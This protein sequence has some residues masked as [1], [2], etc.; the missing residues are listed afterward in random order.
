MLLCKN[1]KNIP[2]IF[3]AALVALSLSHTAFAQTDAQSIIS[4]AENQDSLLSRIYASDVTITSVPNEHHVTGT[5]LIR[6]SE[7]ASI[8]NIQYEVMLLSPLQKG[9]INQLIADAPDVYDRVRSAEVLTLKS[10]EKR[11]ID[12]SYEAP[13]VPQGS[14]RLRIQIVTTNDRK[15]G[16]DDATLTLGGATSFLIVTPTHVLA[17]SSDPITKESG[18]T[19]DPLYGVN[20]DPRSRIQFEA[21]IKNTGAD[22]LSGTVITSTKRLLYANQ[23]QDIATQQSISI[24]ATSSKTITIPVTTETTPGAY[25]ILLTVV[26]KDHNKISGVGEYRY[27]VRGQSASVVSV[28]I[29]SLPSIEKDLAR[30][31]FVLGGSADRATP[32]TGTVTISITDSSGEVGSVQQT[33]STSGAI[34]ITGNAQVT[35]KKVLC[36]IPTVT[37]SLA[38]SSGKPLDSY[39]TTA[40]AFANP[41]C[42]PSIASYFTK[43]VINTLLGAIALMIIGVLIRIRVTRK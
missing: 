24:P 38:D 3:I 8:G 28:Q 36:G 33:F 21:A 40:P 43:P 27:V 5:F 19:W 20:V 10:G 11:T 17:K 15:L 4:S 32:V 12:F 14:Y 18:S 25:I 26:D 7:N 16:W 9:P 39:T 37:I 42:K 35:M 22:Q 41:S 2:M 30:L 23:P 31:S 13:N 29:A 1:M 6:N 34:P